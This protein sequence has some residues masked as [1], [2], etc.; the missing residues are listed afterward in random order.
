M[1]LRMSK[2]L[3][4]DGAATEIPRRRIR[5]RLVQAPL[6]FRSGRIRQRLCLVADIPAFPVLFV[7]GRQACD[8]LLG[9]RATEAATNC[10]TAGLAFVPHATSAFRLTA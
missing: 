4:T 10:P 6:H 7:P 1:T 8:A 2:A 9:N 3:R 5:A